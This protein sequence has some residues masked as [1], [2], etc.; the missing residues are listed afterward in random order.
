LSTGGKTKSELIER[1]NYQKDMISELRREL[2]S[3]PK[4]IDELEE[5]S[6]QFDILRVELQKCVREKA[7]LEA[8]QS[9]YVMSVS[10]LNTEKHKKEMA[11]MQRDVIVAQ[12]EQYRT[13]VERLRGMYERPQERTSRVKDI[14]DNIVFVP[15]TN[16]MEYIEEV[17]W[18]NQIYSKC[19]ES[20]IIFNKRL[21]FAFHTALKTSEWS[22]ITVLAG[23]SGTGKSELPRLYARYGGM[24]YLSLAVQP[25]WDSPQSLLGYFNS[26]DNKFN[27]TQLLSAMVQFQGK[28]DGKITDNDLSDKML[29][30]LLDEMNLAHVELYFSELLSKL[31]ERRGKED[32]TNIDIDLGSALKKYQ[33]NLSRNVLWVGTMNEDE[34]TKTLSDKVLDRSNLITFPRP[35]SFARRSEAK[36]AEAGSI[37]KQGD[38][39]KWLKNKVD[40]SESEEILRYKEG[41]EEI[42]SYLENAGRAL[43]HRIWQSI[44]NYMSN[45]P[46]VIQA[47]HSEDKEQYEIQ[48]NMAFEEALVYKVMPKLR[49]IETTGKSK[50]KCLEPIE[51]KISEIAPGLKEDFMRARDSEYG[52]F[53]WKSSQYLEDSIGE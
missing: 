9:R 4:N 5:K 21:L 17:D 2:A 26:I 31:E 20:G 35:K 53:L 52:L 42:N 23:V 46:L 11:E 18:L 41:L 29:L 7:E 1:I 13:E 19:E 32:G 27:A 15:N 28:E 44:E 45:H 16:I 50:T 48:L 47:S 40:F 14:E 30:V 43:G 34:T 24:Y 36:L 51:K 8:G 3:R 22:P 12:M 49:G 6:K 37:L 25:D 33:V 38:W 39:N 10:Q